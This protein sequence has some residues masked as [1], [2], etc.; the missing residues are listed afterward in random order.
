MVQKAVDTIASLVRRLLVLG[1]TDESTGGGADV[2]DVME[3]TAQL[4][5]SQFRRTKVSI[6]RRPPS[7]NLRVA[8]SRAELTQVLTNLLINAR[9]AMPEGGTVTIS[10]EADSS[11]A[12]I[13]VTDRGCGIA[14]ELLDRI[15][16]PFFTTKGN[17]G[18]GLGLSV[19]ESLVRSNGGR[20]AVESPPGQ[21]ATF[22][23]SLPRFS[24]ATK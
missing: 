22:V 7:H 20:I 6:E 19:T 21:G 8:M 1:S 9:D 14:P 23:V 11:M 13:H 17:K 3:F 12:S 10:A 5:E 18:T 2:G 15:F 24:G 4:L 16:V